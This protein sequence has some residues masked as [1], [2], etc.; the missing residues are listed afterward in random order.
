M[1]QITLPDG[2]K[3]DYENPVS[4]AAIAAIHWAR[5]CQRQLWR[6][7]LMERLVDTTHTLSKQDARGG[8]YHRP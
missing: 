4:V 5:A 7:A 1:P 6:V 2:S 8:D 3:R